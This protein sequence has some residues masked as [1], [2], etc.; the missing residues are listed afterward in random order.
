MD[1]EEKKDETGED[2]RGGIQVYLVWQL[3]YRDAWPA[4]L[5]RTFKRIFSYLKERLTENMNISRGTNS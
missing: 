4:Q 1:G 3:Q 2:N 5:C